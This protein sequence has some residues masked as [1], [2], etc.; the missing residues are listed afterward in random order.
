MGG[1][2]WM[3]P[4]VKVIDTHSIANNVKKDYTVRVLCAIPNEGHTHV[5]AYIN[6]LA[7]FA[8]LGRLEKESKDYFKIL[9]LFGNEGA[10]KFLDVSNY[11]DRDYLRGKEFEFYLFTAGRMFTPIARNEAVKHAI[12]I[13]ADYLFFID[14]DMICPDD[15]FERLYRHNV[16]IV[17]P[18]AFTRNYPH[19]PVIYIAKEGWDPVTRSSYYYNESVMKYPKDSLIRVDSHGFGAALIKMWV[20]KKTKDPWFALTTDT[21]EDIMFCIQAAKVGAKVYSDT[22][23]KLGHLGHP[24]NITEDY[25]EE[26]RK[27]DNNWTKKNGFYNK[28]ETVVALGE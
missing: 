9:D 24:P 26:I 3:N 4:V 1:T 18:L 22:S 8:H 14:D 19:K 6:R 27:Y 15:L 25:V 17:C 5:E 10:R 2:N 7:N 16:D 12:D 21:G 20:F 28:Y 11:M 23:T 13:D